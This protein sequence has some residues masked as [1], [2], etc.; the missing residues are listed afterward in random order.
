M[1]MISRAHFFLIN[2]L[3]IGGCMAGEP[4]ADDHAAGD[5]EEVTSATEQGLSQILVDT[6][7]IG[8]NLF[9]QD[10]PYATTANCD[11]GFVRNS[12]V[13]PSTTWS[14]A[15]G[16]YCLF[17]SWVNPGNPADCRANMLAH[18]PGGWSAGTCTTYVTEQAPDAY[19]YS[20]ANTAYA[21]A[22]TVDRSIA[23]GAGQMLTIGTC[24]VAG[25]SVSGDSFLRLNGPGGNEITNNDDGCSGSLGSKLSIFITQSGFYT[26]RAGC[27]SS[28][29]CS[30]TVAWTIQ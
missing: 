28:G 27:Y 29:A 15:L 7:N 12:G 19:S 13:I 2:C 22:N 9:A 11:P 25:A 1:D 23:L 21:Q 14:S 26:I 20:A 24:G 8:G 5:G 3:A 4:P 10:F 16:G 30:G 6:K 17:Q 18:L